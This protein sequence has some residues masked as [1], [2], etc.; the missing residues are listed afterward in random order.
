MSWVDNASPMSY[1]IL[2]P[3]F[4]PKNIFSTAKCSSEMLDEFWV[5]LYLCFIYTEK[6]PEVFSV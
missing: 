6:M 5:M 4:N 2:N 1:L 3:N